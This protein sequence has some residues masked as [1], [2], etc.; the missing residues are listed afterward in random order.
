MRVIYLATTEEK[1]IAAI[2]AAE[3][4]ALSNVQLIR[5]L[6]N[7]IPKPFDSLTEAA[8]QTNTQG[9]QQVAAAERKI[10]KKVSKKAR[11]S[12]RNLSKALREANA[13][14]RLKNGQLRKGKTQKDVMR[15]AQKL[16]K[17]M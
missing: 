6:K 16:K 12:R 17:K 2:N 10:V 8:I 13:K 3:A 1:A 15:L 11:E 5:E 7:I 4:L 14:L 9:I